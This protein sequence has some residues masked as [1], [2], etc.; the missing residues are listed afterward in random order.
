MEDRVYLRYTGHALSKMKE[1]KLFAKT[2]VSSIFQEPF[3]TSAGIL[4][5]STMYQVSFGVPQGSVLGPLLFLLY[6]NDI[7]EVV[8][9][10]SLLMM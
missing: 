3:I 9:H 7:Q 1:R 8:Q 5:T 10:S 4:W 2:E 6:I